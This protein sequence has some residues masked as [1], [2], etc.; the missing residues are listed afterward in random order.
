MGTLT[1]LKAVRIGTVVITTM[2]ASL[3]FS[4]PN[5]LSYQGRIV[6]TDNTPLE[7][8]GVEFEFSITNPAGDC[9]IY[10]E[11]S[12]PKD[13][14]N[15]KGLF[16]VP[17]GSGT[18]NYPS[19]STFKVLDSFKNGV[20][21]NCEGGGT[22]LAADGDI[23]LLRVQFKDGTG[24]KLISPDNQI[25]SV[26]FAGY[27]DNAKSAQRLEDKVVS[28][29]VLKADLPICTAGKFL[30]HISPSGTFTCDDVTVTGSNVV[31]NISG[32]SAGFTGNLTG[33]VTGTQSTTSV[34][35]IKNV[36]LNMTG[37][38]T[39]KVLKYNGTNWAPADD[40]TGGGA[41]GITALTGD[42][43]A[44]GTGSVA[45]T[46]SDDT[47]TSAKI[48]NGTILNE[49]INAAAAIAD[50]KLATISTAGKVSGSAITSGTI[51]GSTSINTSGMI[52][53]S[54]SI[55]LYS[56]SNKYTE[57]KSPAGLADDQIFQLP[58]T[59]GTS[60]QVLTTN[61][62]GILSWQT[63]SGG[64]GGT[65]TGVTAAAPLAS[66]GGATPNITI[67][68]A[69]TGADG[70][71]SSTDWNTFNNKLGTST[72]F[73]GDVSGTYNV[74]VVDKIKGK[75]VVPVTYATGQTLRYDGTNWV[76][77]L[78]NAASDI[79][80]TLGLANGGTGATTAAGARTNLEL[81][82]SA[83]VDTG[84]SSGKVPLIGLTGLTADRVCTADS[85]GNSIQCNTNVSSLSPW[86][87][88]V[89]DIYNNNSGNVGIGTT[90]P[91]YKLH[92]NGTGYF[93]NTVTLGLN[94]DIAMNGGTITGMGRLGI[95]MSPT[96]QVDINANSSTGYS[97]NSTSVQSPSAT[98]GIRTFNS[99]ASDGIGAFYH[100]GVT[101]F[102]GRNQTAY[103]GA[104]SNSGSSSYRPELV[105][106]T[107][108]GASAYAESMRIAASGNIGM[109]TTLPAYSLDIYRANASANLRIASD[110]SST[111]DPRYPSLV[112]E[113]FMGSPATDGGGS[114]SMALV[115]YRG[116][117]TGS[118][119]AMRAGESIGSITFSGSYNTSGAYK[120]GAG[121]WARAAENYT[122][123]TMGTSLHF[124]TA[125]TG[126]GTST[127]KMTML[128]TGELGVDRTAPV[129]K[130]DVNGGV[131][132]GA[133][134]T[135]TA[136]KSGMIAYNSSNIQFCVNGAWVALGSGGS[137]G[138]F[139][140]DGTVSMTAPFKS[141]SGGASA[142]GFAFAAA[143]TVGIFQAS[144]NMGL[145]TA[146]LERLTILAN[147][148]VGV[149]IN[150]PAAQLH[151]STAAAISQAG[152]GATG[153]T[154]T[155]VKFKGSYSS[156]AAVQ[157]GDSLGSLN[158]GGTY[159]SSAYVE[160]SASISAQ[161]A[162][163]FSSTS[164]PTNLV[165]KTTATGSTTPTA[166]ITIL[167]NGNV[168]I[169]NSS[170]SQPL[171]VNGTI[172]A[173]SVSATSFAGGSVNV[174]TVNTGIV[175]ATGSAPWWAPGVLRNTEANGYSGLGFVDSDGNNR[176]FVAYANASAVWS[177]SAVTLGS[178]DASI[179][180]SFTMG[181]NEVGRFQANTG[182]FGIGVTPTEKLHVNGNGKFTGSVVANG[183]TL[184]SDARFKRNIASIESPLE[185]IL[186]IRGV[187]YDWRQEE[188][189]ERHF[190]DR[191]QLGVIAQ[192]IEAQFPEAV[193]TDK[194]GYKSVSYT[195]L[196]APLIEAVK[197]LYAHFS[198]QDRK[199]ASLEE[200]N[201]SLKSSNEDLKKQSA[202]MQQALCE[203]G[204][205]SFCK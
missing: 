196:V 108:T 163:T 28:D 154:S 54:N 172:E 170:P 159:S 60:G 112:I 146:G 85:T 161:A 73:A 42:V 55:R 183:V 17:I 178:M 82:T 87:T 124:Y 22:Y 111:T 113:N 19:A 169:G 65:V 48:V 143:P 152:A 49:D 106:G 2:L 81:G 132:V 98:T 198:E 78:I 180:L 33:D 171:S 29:F 21:F 37:L 45:A 95:N 122:S 186:N 11:T 64:G 52:Q 191:K 201:Q 8:D 168:G 97:Y 160:E 173:S 96:A 194:A 115:N 109:G 135:C 12:S 116:T 68:Q 182:N 114:P 142:P 185:K 164:Y 27:S 177:P 184:T 53:T 117:S 4:A 166:R 67:T 162:G 145:A 147:G 59:A 90:S 137:G 130:L 148:N 91:T 35:R 66:S 57:I 47:V 5:F 203:L 151:V 167:A 153:P 133:D 197:E 63:I 20:T 72:T 104:V 99:A 192:E 149:G 102:A 118:T 103:V 188:F 13:M 176:G 1:S 84:N 139:K 16:D 76:N 199:I 205:K 83:I 156:Y 50:S 69:A 86:T 30:R 140:S 18:K 158:F 123:T 51:G 88:A 193:D 44:T 190:S 157:S 94:T 119:A 136:A 31:G 128:S 15:S 80:G 46:L 93:A 110:N 36:P 105:F 127:E 202:Q 179:P 71:L 58:P 200:A 187:T 125:S 165:L 23:R 89:A 75:S 77:A 121:I 131:R 43:T 74:T 150:A 39:G 101:N 107:S 38:A 9:R 26:P 3:A 32:S 10:R 40:D 141:Y 138:D 79:T 174:G 100:M 34:D 6:K 62:A 25:R 7:E 120:E 61:G 14:R 41:T 144:G 175:N 189:P 204:K 195:S 92:V 181:G 129:A 56:D 24:W 155:F 134:A 126:S 70:Y